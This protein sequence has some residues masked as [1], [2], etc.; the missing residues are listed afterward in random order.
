MFFWERMEKFIQQFSSACASPY[1]D[2]L[3]FTLKSRRAKIVAP[4]HSSSQTCQVVIL[5]E[6]TE[7]QKLSLYKLHLLQIGSHLN[8]LSV[9]DSEFGQLQLLH[10]ISW[11]IDQFLDCTWASIV[12]F[13]IYWKTTF[14]GL[15]VLAIQL[16]LPQHSHEPFCWPAC[17]VPQSHRPYIGSF[18]TTKS[19]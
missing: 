13:F 16:A 1:L 19:F 5:Q 2:I 15:N 4:Q 7:T 8:L 18:K 17:R 3:N 9:L 10:R 14:I 12:S 11:I 6:K